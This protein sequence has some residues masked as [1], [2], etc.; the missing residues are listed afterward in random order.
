MN[1]AFNGRP[2][3]MHERDIRKDITQ[4][5]E[6]QEPCFRLF[7]QIIVL[8]DKVI[9]L[10]RPPD[11]SHKPVLDMDFLSFEDLVL[12]CGGFQI[13]MAALGM[14]FKCSSPVPRLSPS[15]PQEVVK[16]LN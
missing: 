2:V 15:T 7:L 16:I 6:E 4:C 8:L 5:F 11:S 10:Y 3:L 13:G 14:S 9:E 12:R 1:A